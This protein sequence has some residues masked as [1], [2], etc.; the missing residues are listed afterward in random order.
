MSPR[1]TRQCPRVLAELVSPIAHAELVKRS[2]GPIS[3]DISVT[4]KEPTLF[5]R[6]TFH[7]L[8]T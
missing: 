6:T 8:A 4:I 1:K 2:I 3:T 7:I 5:K